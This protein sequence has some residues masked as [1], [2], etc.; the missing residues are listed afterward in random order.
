MSQAK[1]Q[2]LSIE[3]VAAKTI[4]GFYY[5]FLCTAKRWLALQPREVLWCEGNEDVD[6]LDVKGA[7]LSEQ[8]KHL[9]GAVTAATD[10][11]QDAIWNF[12]RVF[13]D[14]HARNVPARFVFRTTASLGKA[15]KT[16]K[17]V[18]DWVAGKGQPKP[19]PLLTFLNTI[20]KARTKKTP[21]VR[22]QVMSYLN[23]DSLVSEFAAS[24]DWV[25]GACDYAELHERLIGELAGDHRMRGLDPME[26]AN[27]MIARIL[28]A[29]SFDDVG[30][31][32]LTS[33]DLELLVND[34]H[35]SKAAKWFGRQGGAG[36]E[37]TVGIAAPG[38]VC[39][40]AILR[41]A[42]VT[43][44][45]R[46][47]EALLAEQHAR[48]HDSVLSPVEVLESEWAR[49]RLSRLDFDIY[50]AYGKMADTKREYVRQRW[51]IARCLQQAR[52]RAPLARTFVLDEHLRG[53][54]A[55]RFGDVKFLA[56]VPHDPVL[57]LAALVAEWV[58]QTMPNIRI[59]A[60]ALPELSTK[61][62]CV[63][64]WDDKAIFIQEDRFGADRA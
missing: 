63:T 11:V 30:G 58:R 13:V 54:L 56:I 23:S 16:S 36:S 7:E 39:C 60:G 37:V 40:C 31:R 45:R 2:I 26:I 17:A 5:Q 8:V 38:D 1:R 25:F 61:L 12:L 20:A 41:C 55:K 57:T 15:Q 43:D 48:P 29:S 49:E 22:Q 42:N 44:L 34:A 6:I 14:L 4:R 52:A 28:R 50:A 27:A 21:L 3:R 53:R 19:G 59:G 35:L 51:L 64:S 10:G 33:L 46:D 9:G 62:R 18:L 32:R 24:V 47:V